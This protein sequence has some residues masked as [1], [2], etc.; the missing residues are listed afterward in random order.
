MH[1]PLLLIRASAG[2]GKTYTLV[3]RFL[4][5]LLRGVSPDRILASTFTRKAAAEIR[6]RI[7]LQLAAAAQTASECERLAVAVDLPKLTTLDCLT[8]LQRLASLQHRLTISTIDGVAMRIARCSA[9]EIGVSPQ[10]GILED[11]NLPSVRRMALMRLKSNVTREI[12]LTIL[13]ELLQNETPTSLTNQLE[14][15]L[16][17]LL[18]LAAEL[19]AQGL[20]SLSVPEPLDESALVQ[21]T[22]HAAALEA[23]LTKSGTPNLVWM[24]SLAKLSQ[25]LALRDWNELA[26]H[27]FVANAGDQDW[28][29]KGQTLPAAIRSVAMQIQ[30]HL[31]AIFAE[32]AARRSAA[33]V[34]L[35]LAYF[36][37]YKECLTHLGAYGFSD[38]KHIV[39][40]AMSRHE[41]APLLFRLDS[42]F[43]HVLL[44]E[45]Q[46]TSRLDWAMLQPLIDGAASGND[47]NRS[48]LCVGDP[49]QGIY[50]WRGG[51][52]DI[53]DYVVTKYP[54]LAQRDLAL[55]RR[56]SA[57]IT[58]FVNELFPKLN[59]E[60]FD[61]HQA[62]TIVRWRNNFPPHS[63]SRDNV[64]GYV[65][66]SSCE[67][68]QL[69]ELALARVRELS[70]LHSSGT[71]AV[72][73]RSNKQL[74]DFSKLAQ[75]AAPQLVFSREGKRLLADS[76]AVRLLLSLLRLIDHPNDSVSSYHLNASVLRALHGDL[77][78]Q[79][80]RDQFSMRSRRAIASL[81]LAK[82]LAPSVECLRNEGS[83][84]DYEALRE[85]L[86]LVDQ[87]RPHERLS[88]LIKRALL[89]Q[90]AQAQ[91]DR[92][93]LMT[94]HA[95]KGL[96][97]DQV[98][99]PIDNRGLFVQKSRVLVDRA[100]AMSAPQK[101]VRCDLGYA[102]TYV[103]E[104][105]RLHQQADQY[106]ITE[107]INLLYVA[108]TRARDELYVIL[109][110]KPFARS[111][112]A[113]VRNSLN[114][115]E[116]SLR[117]GKRRVAD[118]IASREEESDLN[119]SAK[120]GALLKNLRPSNS[121]AAR[122]AVVNAASAGALK[123]D[124]TQIAQFAGDRS[125]L[126][127]AG[128]AAHARMQSIEWL[129][130]NTAELPRE[131][132]EL[133]RR[134]RFANSAILEVWRERRFAV[135]VQNEI[136][137]GRFDRVVLVRDDK[138]R[139][140]AAELVDFKSGLKKKAEAGEA[141]ERYRAQLEKYVAALRALL[142]DTKAPIKM[143]VAFIEAGCVLEL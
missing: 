60:S 8:A 46:D 5:L 67:Y 41:L 12:L 137:S 105:R 70:A 127:Q 42:R 119:V 24:K 99:V 44:D 106:G 30:P 124:L 49:K 11:L 45:F 111:T 58:R 95:A 25:A 83:S 87:Y 104:L 135:K 50:G 37:E 123:R 53:F 96:E 61:A 88:L 89:C 73:F 68:E 14:R 10:L 19:P 18:D 132:F 9:A 43:E 59:T 7:F 131:I 90:Y 113:L 55:T 80:Q 75:Q 141:A 92:I 100:D 93:R 48:F 84:S 4:A 52:V 15:E 103:P 98:V 71:I 140:L 36:S 47:S 125:I 20:Q 117:I 108:L 82:F 91:R 35:L 122:I 143:Q 66:V 77:S 65:E 86:F 138:R 114:L 54:L 1:D 112:A 28:T 63:T 128:I 97:F 69:H 38:L 85:F 40:S 23:P 57:A 39:A 62:A 32:R 27:S 3:V 129:E 94:I 76:P 79:P 21:I 134:D 115:S 139:V 22:E 116:G 78:E 120:W 33:F 13:S 29:Y 51:V 34:A 101:I 56:S 130:D 26:G 6:Q 118:S 109:P 133:F 72:L 81:G 17:D 31:A 2:S 136:I 102:R 110:T 121:K 126:R 16:A 142:G 74:T 64:S 107:A